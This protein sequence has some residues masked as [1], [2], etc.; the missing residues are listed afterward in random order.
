MPAA[1]WKKMANS[2]AISLAGA[3]PT[4][5]LAASGALGEIG[6]PT[7]VL[8]SGLLSVLANAIREA[9]KAKPEGDGGAL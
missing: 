5:L 7:A 3:I 4:I 6:S 1:F 8:V 9:N 2:I